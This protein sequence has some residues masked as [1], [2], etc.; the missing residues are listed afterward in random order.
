M[1]LRE[2]CKAEQTAAEKVSRA[3]ESLTR[4]EWMLSVY[5]LIST[6]TDT[7]ILV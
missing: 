3:K 4:A 2:R 7:T 1:C 5:E 6:L